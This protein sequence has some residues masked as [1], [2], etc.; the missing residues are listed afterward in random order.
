MENGAGLSD[1]LAGQIDLENAIRATPADSLFLISAGALPPNPA[2][3][4]GSRKMQEL[5]ER[6]RAQFEFIFIDS[7][8]ILAVSDSV[9][10]ST[11]VDGSL[12][13]INR[14]T[15]KPLIRKA[16]ARLS[17]SRSK[18][19]GLLLNQVDI[20]NSDYGGYYQQYYTYYRDS[21]P[22]MLANGSPNFVGNGNGAAAH[23]PSSNSGNGHRRSR[24][25]RKTG[26]ANLGGDATRRETRGG[27]ALP[28]VLDLVQARFIR[29]VGPMAPLMIQE[30]VRKM[31]ESMQ[32]FPAARLQELVSRLTAEIP[33]IG[34]RR[35]FAEAMREEIE[36]LRAERLTRL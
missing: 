36:N 24:R 9:L 20:H 8:P 23:E 2:E 14:R 13:V 32:S 4:L 16:R 7:S 3:L 5:L 28:S 6:L 33:N 27:A 12:L 29:A 26:A 18:I 19:L 30:H 10:L 11:M 15:A 31:G 22:E 21:D 25:P 35:Q 17:V 34:F 1:L